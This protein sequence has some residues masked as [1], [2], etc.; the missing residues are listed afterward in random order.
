MAHDP[1]ICPTPEQLLELYPVFQT[2][3]YASGF[4]VWTMDVVALGAGVYITTIASTPYVYVSDGT[5]ADETALR[6]AILAVFQATPVAGWVTAASGPAGI[7]INS[8]VDGVG[9]A[10]TSN[11]GPTGIE[12]TLAQTT[13]LTPGEIILQALEFAGCMVCDWGCSTFNACMAAAVH[14]LKMWGQGQS[15]GA[16]PSGQVTSMTQGPFSVS[17]A[18]AQISSGSDGW[19]AGTPEGNQFLF[20]RKQQGPKPLRLRGG[21]SCYTPGPFGRSARSGVRRLY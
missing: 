15:T 18:T 12:L 16:G 2:P 13:P 4:V 10:V 11:L 7:T 9:L 21:A 20:L 3:P 6:D 19:W 14:W 17:F 1:N 5:E 8:T